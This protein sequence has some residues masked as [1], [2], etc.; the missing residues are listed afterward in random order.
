MEYNEAIY[1][2]IQKYMTDESFPAES[3]ASVSSESTN[4]VTETTS[5]I[6]ETEILFKICTDEATEEEKRLWLEEN[7]LDES[8]FETIKTNFRYGFDTAKQFDSKVITNEEKELQKKKEKEEMSQ[9]LLG[10]KETLILL[11][12]KISAFEKRFSSN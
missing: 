4:E 1:S 5:G 8:V 2:V 3:S 12:N 9:E 10:I 11:A 7:G 6:Q